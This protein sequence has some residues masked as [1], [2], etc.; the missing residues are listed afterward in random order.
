METG[1]IPGMDQQAGREE[2]GREQT[3]VVIAS[4]SFHHK[5]EY[6]TEYMY[7]IGGQNR[8]QCYL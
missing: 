4:G 8:A 7:A 1:G 3:R 6:A 5:R 2:V